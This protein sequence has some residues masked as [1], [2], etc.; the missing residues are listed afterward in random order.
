M[1]NE[2]NN[3]WTTKGIYL[4]LLVV[5][6][7]I[8][9]VAVVL[10][11]NSQGSDTMDN[12]A[13]T[14]NSVSLTPVKPNSNSTSTSQSTKPSDSSTDSTQDSTV[15]PE[16]ATLQ[17]SFIMPVAGGR[18]IKEYTEASVVY[19][20]T[21]GVYA[22]HMGMDVTGE[23]SAEVLAVYDGEITSITT[24]YLEGTTVVVT[25]VNGVKTI[26]NSI[27]VDDALSVGD[28]VK[29]GDVLGTISTNNRQEYKDGAHLHFE[30]EEDGVKVSPAKYFL[31]YDK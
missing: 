29:Q 24:N 19:N 16:P 21:L 27:E 11:V 31:G 9:T 6:I 2:N 14:S 4:I 10:S 15:D 7:A 13:T 1:S 30:V 23:D 25:H 22:G 28:K 3:F 12:P 18:I 26:Y 8:V 17:M 20:Q 5:A